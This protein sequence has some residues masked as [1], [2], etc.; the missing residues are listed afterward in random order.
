MYIK[1]LS[2]SQ[3]NNYIKKTMDNDFILKN[4]S[5]KGEISNW[6]RHSSG[7]IYFSL[8][9]DESKINCIMF[10]DYASNIDFETDNGLSVIATGR[11][12]LYSKEGAVQFYCE[13]I[14]LNGV[15]KLHI[16]FEKLK[17]KLQSEGLFD[18]IYKKQIPKYSKKIGIITSPTGAAFRDIINVA[19]RRNDKI[20]LILYPS[21][22]QGE[23]A[24]ENIIRGIKYFNKR[25][26]VELIII[27]R[28]GGSIEELWS[29]NEELLAREIYKS[30]KIII[31]AV[32]HETDF[33]ISDFVSDLRAPTPSAAAEIAVFN[34]N[35]Y[36]EKLDYLKKMIKKNGLNKIDSEKNRLMLYSEK[37][38]NNNPINFIS[39]Q[40]FKIDALKDK[41]DNSI[42]RKIEKE[43]K[44]LA[45]LYELIEE[46]NP[47][48]ILKKGYSLVRDKD[49]KVIKTVENFKEQEEVE[50][51]FSNGSAKIKEFHIL[52]S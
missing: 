19:K 36:V 49:E 4:V 44:S 3:L 6:K 23:A 35:E 28:G 11:V 29:F 9:D 43:S 7:H 37:I 16:E 12:T 17:N 45:H 40:Y 47:L 24:S 25:D 14:E 50:I 38:K 27:S 30:K 31:S 41:I 48:N 46:K 20:D 26:D 2:V 22:V 1:T 8:K 34:I 21:L 5:L 32:G 13:S 33:T 39:N 51:V 15:G 42:Y 18:N 52:D 10:R